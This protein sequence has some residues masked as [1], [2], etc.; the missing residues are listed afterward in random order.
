MVGMTSVGLRV[1]GVLAQIEMALMD[2]AR[3]GCLTSSIC[4]ISS[5][6]LSCTGRL[7]SGVAVAGGAPSW[8]STLAAQFVDGP[9]GAAQKQSLRD[10]QAGR[11]RA[12]S[13]SVQ[14]QEEIAAVGTITVGK[15]VVQGLREEMEDEIVV[16]ADGPNGFLYAAIFDGHAGV[17]SAKFL[18]F[19]V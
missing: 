12:A 2:C 3:P 9:V 10:A 4:A 18:R 14:Q 7:S 16:E 11:P 8:S 17:Y 5:S 1:G 13:G 6:R 15:F 19:E